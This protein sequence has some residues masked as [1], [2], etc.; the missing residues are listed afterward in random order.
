MSTD[1]HYINWTISELLFEISKR[2][3]AHG[4]SEQSFPDPDDRKRRLADILDGERI[5]VLANGAGV[6]Y[7]LAD[8]AASREGRLT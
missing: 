4:V 6:A 2:R 3:L 7:R 8:P 5:D 1:Q